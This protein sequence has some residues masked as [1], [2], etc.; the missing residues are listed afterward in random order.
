MA[1]DETEVVGGFDV[2]PDETVVV[3]GVDVAADEAEVAGGVELPTDD[4]VVVGDVDVAPDTA[5]VPNSAPTPV[6]LAL[7][8]IANSP[9][10]TVRP[11]GVGVGMPGADAD[12]LL[13]G[14]GEVGVGGGGTSMAAGVAPVPSQTF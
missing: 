7:A 9:V 4:T 12:D 2:P 13:I 8:P 10:A 3:G 11:S 6:G 1:A 5:E 14:A